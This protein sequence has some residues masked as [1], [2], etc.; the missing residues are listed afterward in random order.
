MTDTTT[1]EQKELTAENMRQIVAWRRDR[2]PFEEIGRRLTPPGREKPFTRQYMHELYKKALRD[3]PA[4][5][6][7]EHRA[8]DLEL[9]DEALR[10]AL[11]VMR[12]DHIAVSQGRVVRIG[13]PFV[14][15]DGEA[16]IAEGQGAPVHDD[17]PKLQA[18]NTIR[19]LLER[20]AKIVGS[21]SP[22]RVDTTS[23]F[24][25][26]YKINGIDPKALT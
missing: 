4:L 3:I 13:K 18:I 14:N 16:E 7:Q 21:D 1:P 15:D 22:V 19:N 9:I 25:V 8:E 24:T 10:T 17:A 6:V 26:N 23:N 5:E 12:R 2:V 11:A 20:K